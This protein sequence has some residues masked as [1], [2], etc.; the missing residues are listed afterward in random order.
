MK[1]SKHLFTL[2]LMGFAITAI[3]AQAT[4][5]VI[6]NFESTPAGVLTDGTNGWTVDTQSNRSA[7]V[8][9]GGLSY[10]IGASNFSGGAQSLQLDLAG[11]GGSS[12]PANDFISKTFSGLGG[13]GQTVWFAFTL[14]L[15]AD[16][17]QFISIGFSDGPD[18]RTDA[19]AAVIRGID[20]Y[21]LY[22]NSGTRSNNVFDDGDINGTPGTYRFVGYMTYSASGNETT[23]WVMNPT[24][25]VEGDQTFETMSRQLGS[26]LSLDYFGVY[27]NLGDNTTIQLDDIMVGDSFAA[28]VPEPST[29]A[30]LLG[31][32]ALGMVMWR[33]RRA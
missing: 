28:V 16:P 10:S 20:E 6:D 14:G 19:S 24:S 5:T 7:T 15:A 32:G 12:D 17:E 8:V 9:A 27:A 2:P 29:Y 22:D 1:T 23:G 31:L 18:S 11:T 21:R 26:N 30:A 4:V 33:R 13:D 25:F 3:T